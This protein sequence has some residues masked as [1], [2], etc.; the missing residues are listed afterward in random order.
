MIRTCCIRHVS[1]AAGRQ[2]VTVHPPAGANCEIHNTY[3]EHGNAEL[4]SKYG[5]ALHKNPFS[6]VQINKLSILSIASRALS[7]SELKKRRRFLEDE[8]E[9]LEEGEEPFIVMPGEGRRRGCKAPM[10]HLLGNSTSSCCHRSRL[11]SPRRQ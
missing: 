4:V 7:R 11:S 1:V 2:D 10:M 5:F 9:L 3:G 6:E 8:S